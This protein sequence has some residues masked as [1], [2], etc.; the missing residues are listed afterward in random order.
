VTLRGRLALSVSIA[1]V[2]V[3]VIAAVRGE[4]PTPAPSRVPGRTPSPTATVAGPVLADAVSYRDGMYD[5]KVVPSPT[6][7]KSQSKL[8]YASGVWWGLLNEPISHELHIYRLAQDGSSWTDT[9]TIVDERP[10][11]R[12]DALAV[13]DGLY[14]ATAGPR[15]KPVD[16]IRLSRFTFADGLY[17]LDI[18]YPI[19]L[20]DTGVESVVLARDGAD[21]LWVAY[22]SQNRVSIRASDG[23]DHHWSPI[24]TPAIDGTLVA[25]DDI[26]AVVPFG[27]SIGLMWSNQLEDAVYFSAHRDQDPVAVWS[28]SEV[29]SRGQRQPDDHINMK[30]DANGRVYAVLK[31]SL[32]TLPNANPL[33]PQ[34]VLAVRD[35]AG[36]W[37]QHV[38]ARVKDH[39]TRPIV[40]IDEESDTLY[41]VA[42]SPSTGG[43][44]Y[45]K[46]ASLGD[47]SFETG[48]GTL[49]VS[50]REGAKI[51]NATSTKQSITSESDL[52]VL[53]SDNSVARY[54][55]GILDIGGLGVRPSPPPAP[56]AGEP[57]LVVNDA[58]DSWR[59]GEALPAGWV[60]RNVAK[61]GATVQAR[62]NRG[63]VGRV[64]AI[65]D[66][67]PPRACRAFAPITTGR[68]LV[69]FDV[70]VRGTGRTEAVLALIRGAGGDAALVRFGSRGRFSYVQG[71]KRIQTSARWTAE[72][73]YGVTIDLDVAARSMTLSIAD[74]AGHTVLPRTRAAWPSAATS[75][76]EIC[77]QAP[78]GPARPAIEFDALRVARVRP[79]D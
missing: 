65:T 63:G 78:A 53:A 43:S 19:V 2:S 12:G 44:I 79:P 61:G 7:S 29:V 46:R 8:W 58:F 57:I 27:D 32:D 74:E 76:D 36:G 62:G 68:V 33:A 54:F 22:T 20:N 25:A 77:F 34:I 24:L 11:A 23:D 69:D 26:A 38:V 41:V 4:S 9:G 40:L 50:G 48:L 56:P 49:L 60:G 35:Q 17:R 71:G 3:A 73:W 10:L 5:P 70:R 21:R 52:I 14:V 64:A 28:P 13:G 67:P 30:A 42:T 55:H 1:I 59:D 72:T 39:H 45:Y 37:R 18:D 31:T 66:G 15:T 16:A 6:A 75:V 47:V 51:S